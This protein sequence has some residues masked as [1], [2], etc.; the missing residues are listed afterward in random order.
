MA[1]S[2]SCSLSIQS[3]QQGGAERTQ[4]A[5]YFPAGEAIFLL[6]LL[7]SKETGSYLDILSSSSESLEELLY[8]S[9]HKHPA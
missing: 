5:K 8:C 9:S 7:G 3:S 6:L 1:P 2:L 4:C